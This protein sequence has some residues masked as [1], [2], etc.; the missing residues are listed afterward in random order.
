MN[1]A[2]AAEGLRQGGARLVRRSALYRTEPVGVA[3]Q[4]EFL[5]QAA[6][7]DWSGSARSLL[8]LCLEVESSLG[9]SRNGERRGPR[10]IDLDLLL[11]G[12]AVVRQAGIDVP[13]PRMHLR[14]FVLVPLAEIAP[15]AMHPVE[16]LSVKELLLRC[17]DG[18]RVESMAPARKGRDCAVNHP[19][20]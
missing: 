16:R 2:R 14:R 3:G 1:L 8:D 4:G 18:S 20:L 13:H 5:N 10:T 15:D 19:T 7:C 9:R 6:A 12:E 17:P 11:F